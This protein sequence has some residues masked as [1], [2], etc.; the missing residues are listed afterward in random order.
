MR[1]PLRNR[2][3]PF[4]RQLPVPALAV[5]ITLLRFGSCR[6]AELASALALQPDELA[7]WLHFLAITGLVVRDEHDS[8]Q[9]PARVR[10]RLVPELVALH[11]FTEGAA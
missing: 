4:L 2:G 1:T 9:C 5:L 8:H 3:L 6:A 7:R 11:V 10:D